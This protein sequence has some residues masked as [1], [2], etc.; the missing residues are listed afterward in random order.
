VLNVRV[1]EEGAQDA[2]VREHEDSMG[3]EFDSQQRWQDQAED[4]YTASQQ[5]AYE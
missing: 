3:P 4:Y 5:I 1:E 2:E